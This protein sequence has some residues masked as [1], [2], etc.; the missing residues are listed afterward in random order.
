[1]MLSPSANKSFN[2]RTSIALIPAFSGIDPQT[3]TVVVVGS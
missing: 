3:L 1:M 2:N